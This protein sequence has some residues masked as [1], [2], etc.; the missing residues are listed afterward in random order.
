MAL[1][2]YSYHLNAL[3]G[4]LSFGLRAGIYDYVY[5]FGKA[6]VK[7]AGDV[8]NTGSRSSKVTGTAD[9]GAYYYTKTFYW[10]FSMNHL[11]RGKISDMAVNDTSSRQ[12][13]H[14]FMPVGKAFEVGSVVLNPS[15][16]IKYAAHSPTQVD[17]NMNVLLKERLWLG[18]SYRTGYGIVFL[19]QYLISEKLKVGYSFDYG[20]NKIGVAG[21]ATH[22]IMIG[23]E[24]NVKGAKMEMLRY[25]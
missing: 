11:N 2:S 6:K 4:K 16:L 24:L 17:I 25:F 18:A 22:E 21:R 20:F 9:F 10:G 13:F 1:G 15:L 12:A 7:D 8:Y 23:Y 14:F 19:T 5:D 3:K